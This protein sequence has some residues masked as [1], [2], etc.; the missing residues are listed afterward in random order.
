MQSCSFS[1]RLCH[2]P[3]VVGEYVSIRSNSCHTARHAP[4]RQHRSPNT[5]EPQHNKTHSFNLYIF[6]ENIVSSN[7]L[8]MFFLSA[9]SSTPSDARIPKQV[10]AWP[11]ASMAYSTWYRRPE[12]GNTNSHIM[13]TIIPSELTFRREY[14]RSCIVASGLEK[15]QG[16]A[17]LVPSPVTDTTEALTILDVKLHTCI[18]D[19]VIFFE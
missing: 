7:S 9:A 6:S 2:T 19:R 14:S 5:Q 13:Y 4:T 1:L 11:I 15:R 12:Q 10:P 17:M 18:L 16:I 8:L 3:Q